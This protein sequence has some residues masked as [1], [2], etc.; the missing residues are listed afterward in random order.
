MVNLPNFNDG[1]T[2]VVVPAGVAGS[3]QRI[4]AWKKYW[5]AWGSSA[6]TKRSVDG[7]EESI[8]NDIKGLKAQLDKYKVYKLKGFN[9]DQAVQGT[10][11]AVDALN[12]ALA[13]KRLERSKAHV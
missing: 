8:I 13:Q 10:L 3:K 6:A 4:D 5:N 2:P 11:H 12:L 7:L 1:S 9:V